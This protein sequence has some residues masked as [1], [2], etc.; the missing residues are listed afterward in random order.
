MVAFWIDYADRVDQRTV[1]AWQL[2][3]TPAPGKSGKREAL[4][5]WCRDDDCFLTL[6][7]RSPQAGRP[8]PG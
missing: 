8:A 1:R 5:L 3:T 2:L 6:K 7:E 4:G